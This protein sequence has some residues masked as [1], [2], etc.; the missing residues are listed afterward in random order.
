[1]P[2]L[3]RETIDTERQGKDE[4]CSEGEVPG[5]I[6]AFFVHPLING[7]DVGESALA[8]LHEYQNLPSLDKTD[9]RIGERLTIHDLFK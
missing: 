7:E 4:G 1:M 2:F 9:L 6:K 5:D 3:C 8:L